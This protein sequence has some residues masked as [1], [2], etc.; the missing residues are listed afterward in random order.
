[1]ETSEIL[2]IDACLGSKNTTYHTLTESQVRQCL[3]YDAPTKPARLIG[4]EY[5]VTREIYETLDEEE[6]KLWHSHNYEVGPHFLVV[7]IRL[8]RLLH[9]ISP[10]YSSFIFLSHLLPPQYNSSCLGSPYMN[11]RCSLIGTAP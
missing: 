7:Q 10:Q 5:M 4:V 2:A 9:L 11:S 6:R 3:I 8:T 1:M